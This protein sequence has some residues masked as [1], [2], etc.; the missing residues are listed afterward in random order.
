MCDPAASSVNKLLSVKWH[1]AGDSEMRSR[2]G[3]SLQLIVQKWT[4]STTVS[5]PKWAYL[6]QWHVDN[7]LAIIVGESGTIIADF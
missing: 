7:P 1:P 6:S 4:F 3:I 2:L 5:A